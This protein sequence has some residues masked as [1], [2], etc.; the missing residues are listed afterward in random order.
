MAHPHDGNSAMMHMKESTQWRNPIR[1]KGYRIT[2]GC[3]VV[4]FRVYKCKT[5]VIE[6]EP[7]MGTGIIFYEELD[8]DMC[9]TWDFFDSIFRDKLHVRIYPSVEPFRYLVQSIHFDPDYPY[10]YPLSSLHPDGGFLHP[11]PPPKPYYTPPHD[12]LFPQYGL[13]PDQF[14]YSLVPLLSYYPPAYIPPGQ[15]DYDYVPYDPPTDLAPIK[16]EPRSP[17]LAPADTGVIGEPYDPLEYF[18]GFIAQFVPGSSERCS[19]AHGGGSKRGP[20]KE[21]EEDDEM[22][23]T[24]TDD[25]DPP[26]EDELSAGLEAMSLEGRPEISTDTCESRA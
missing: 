23:D 6:E 11:S 2:S 26:E 15:A 14:E 10:D 20:M 9:Q 19:S 12:P 1:S 24:D 16:I 22:V 13:D 8:E 7:T 5:Y 4:D 21:D 17:P 25:E 18:D 3:G